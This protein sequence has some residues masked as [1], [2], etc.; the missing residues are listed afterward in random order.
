L[1]RAPLSFSGGDGDQP[2]G[3]AQVLRGYL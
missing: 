1:T 3:D 2:L